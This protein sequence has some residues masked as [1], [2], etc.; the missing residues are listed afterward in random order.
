LKRNKTSTKE[1]INKKATIKTE[2]SKFEKKIT[3]RIVVYFQRY[4]RE[5]KEEKKM[6]ISNTHATFGVHTLPIIKEKMKMNRLR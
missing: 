1:K 3:M 2:I 4:K 6:I 5:M